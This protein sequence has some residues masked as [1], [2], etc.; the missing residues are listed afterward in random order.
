MRWVL[1]LI[2]GGALWIVPL[3]AM[4]VKGND[5]TLTMDD[6]WTF[7][8]EETS[9]FDKALFFHREM[10]DSQDYLLGIYSHRVGKEFVE[11]FDAALKSD[12]PFATLG[13]FKEPIKFLFS[14]C[15][16][17]ISL[18]VRKVDSI[19]LAGRRALRLQGTFTE[20]TMTTHF[21]I[22]I[23]S[24][25]V[26]SLLITLFMGENIDQAAANEIAAILNSLVVK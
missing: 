15:S 11:G 2:L 25:G 21:Q 4:V 8:S 9:V 18:K 1:S 5:F 20:N 23:V 17:R 6:A 14:F 24:V 3:Q 12:E 10:D 7:E 19:E 16:D 13:K 26:D 22:D